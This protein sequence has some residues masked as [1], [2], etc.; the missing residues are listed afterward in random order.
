M[1]LKLFQKLVNLC[2]SVEQ[3]ESGYVWKSHQIIR[4]GSWEGQ[5]VCLLV[6][7]C[8]ACLSKEGIRRVK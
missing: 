1:K 5:K 7:R 3:G 2:N 4:I 8:S 6:E